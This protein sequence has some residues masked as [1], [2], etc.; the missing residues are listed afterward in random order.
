MSVELPDL[1][2]AGDTLQ[3][4]ASRLAE[5]V[6]KLT[7]DDQNGQSVDVPYEVHLAALEAQTAVVHWTNA[8]LDSGSSWVSP[9]ELQAEYEDHEMAACGSIDHLRPDGENERNGAL[10]RPRGVQDAGR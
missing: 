3:S 10:D 6:L 4:A 8:R 7:R 5:Y 9:A 1:T 2:T